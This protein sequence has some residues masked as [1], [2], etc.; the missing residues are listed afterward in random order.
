MTTPARSALAYQ[1]IGLPSTWASNQNI[2]V[3]TIQATAQ[4]KGSGTTGR[5]IFTG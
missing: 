5:G 3:P 2:T 4:T 1:L